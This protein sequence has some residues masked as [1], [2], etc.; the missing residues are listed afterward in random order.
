MAEAV[1]SNTS[2]SKL[3]LRANNIGDKGVHMLMQAVVANAS[4]QSLDVT[5]NRTALTEELQSAAGFS[6]EEQ[7]MRWARHSSASTFTAASTARGSSK[8]DHISDV[9]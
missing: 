3:V 8:F 6:I 2:L 9:L 1:R 5:D 7:D 4:L